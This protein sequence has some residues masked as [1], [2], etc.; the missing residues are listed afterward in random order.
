LSLADV[1][2]PA[3]SWLRWNVVDCEMLMPGE[4]SS[5]EKCTPWFKLGTHAA[6][7][8]GVK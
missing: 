6:D 8:V 3:F 2:K 7:A 5:A 1:A 4:Y